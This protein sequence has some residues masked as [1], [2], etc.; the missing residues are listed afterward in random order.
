VECR[1]TRPPEEQQPSDRDKH[2]EYEV[3]REHE[4]GEAS[5]EQ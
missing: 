1:R 3:R 2:H 4:I 5:V